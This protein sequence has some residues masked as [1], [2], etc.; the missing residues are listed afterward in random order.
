MKII[1]L[2]LIIIIF[3][4]CLLIGQVSDYGSTTKTYQISSDE[5]KA[6]QLKVTL[7]LQ[8]D[9]NKTYPTLYY[10]DGWWLSEIVL[11]SY[12]ILSLSQQIKEVVFVGITLKADALDWNIQRTFDYTPSKYNLG[13]NMTAG[14]GDNRILLN[15][16][17]TGGAPLFINSLEIKVLKFMDEKYPNLSKKRG[18]LGHSF[19]GLFGFFVMQ[20]KPALFSDYILISPSVWWNKPELLKEEL[21]NKFNE[22]EKMVNIHLSYGEDESKLIK[23]SSI[24][25]DSILNALPNNPTD[26]KFVTYKNTNHNSILPKAIYDGLLFLYKN[27]L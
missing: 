11:G 20:N 25:M 15:E 26:Y 3:Q 10:L 4:N 22:E 14:L 23:E 2:T 21:F 7:P 16:N 5:G 6:Y 1:F 9:K 13:I 18:L 8:Y 27:D 24:K 17:T 12:A 19:R